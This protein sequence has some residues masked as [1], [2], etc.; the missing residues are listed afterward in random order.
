MLAPGLGALALLVFGTA[1]IYLKTGL[2]RFIHADS[3]DMDERQLELSRKAVEKAY[4]VFTVTVLVFIMMLS[5]ALSV[6][7]TAGIVAEHASSLWIILAGLIYY[8]HSL[9]GVFIVLEEQYLDFT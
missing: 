3:A 8:A 9:P 5:I 7:A 1:R 6:D 4:A 2:W